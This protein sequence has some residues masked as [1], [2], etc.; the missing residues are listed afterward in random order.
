MATSGREEVQ[1]LAVDEEAVAVPL[2]QSLLGD[3][4]GITISPLI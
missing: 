3:P 4:D 1:D 2:H